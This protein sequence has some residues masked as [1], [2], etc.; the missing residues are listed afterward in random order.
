MKW[1]TNGNS[2][3]RTSSSEMS[4]AIL[5]RIASCRP[6]TRPSAGDQTKTSSGSSDLVNPRDVQPPSAP[7]AST[8][9]KVTMPE[10]AL[11]GA[12]QRTR[13][14]HRFTAHHTCSLTPAPPWSETR[15]RPDIPSWQVSR[16]ILMANPVATSS[17]FKPCSAPWFFPPD[18]VV[19]IPRGRPGRPVRHATRK[20][21][22]PWTRSHHEGW[23][24]DFLQGLG[25]RSADRVSSWLAA[26]RR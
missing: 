7:H 4:P 22:H 24:K 10:A 9:N 3:P 11:L 12:A 13:S 14:E 26:Q 8:R 19:S 6:S 23:Y 25:H 1:S 18:F 5:K 17:P 2:R 21:P 20:E 16:R 15:S